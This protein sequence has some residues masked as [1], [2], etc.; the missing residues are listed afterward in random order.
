[1]VQIR[2]PRALARHFEIDQR[3]L[4]ALEE[5]N[6]VLNVEPKLFIDLVLLRSSRH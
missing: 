1:M 6:P 5:F 2:N 3:Q 4:D